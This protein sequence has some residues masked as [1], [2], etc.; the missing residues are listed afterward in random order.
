MSNVLLTYIVPV[1]NTAPYLPKCLQSLVNQGLQP[2]EY[3]VIAVDD[4]S[5]DDSREVI[6][7][8]AKDHPQVR[9]VTQANAGVSAAR[10][11]ALD[12]AQGRYVQFVDSDDYLEENV[13]G[14]L[15]HSAYAD[16]LDVLM[17]NFKWVDTDDNFIKVSKPRDDM[18]ATPV[19]SG[20]EFLGSFILSISSIRI[21]SFLSSSFKN[22]L[23]SNGGLP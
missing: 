23:G 6:E 15:L 4:G 7:A 13:M 21:Y 16:N 18:S 19:M 17:F 5:K 22:S 10:N 12:L 3:E 20:T 9:L 14:P 2:D 1:Y 8:F 11:K